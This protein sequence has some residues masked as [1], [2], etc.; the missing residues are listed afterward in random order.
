MMMKVFLILNVFFI[1]L[2]VGIRCHKSHYAVQLVDD[3]LFTL[4]FTSANIRCFSCAPCTEFDY[5]SRWTDH[6][7][8]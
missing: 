7:R 4:Q 8:L 1:K 5:Y 2:K 6:S 3:C